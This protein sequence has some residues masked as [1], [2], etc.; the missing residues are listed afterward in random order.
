[1][2]PG[3]PEVLTAFAQRHFSNM[4]PDPKVEPELESLPQRD[5]KMRR[6][7]AK[8]SLHVHSLPHAHTQNAWTDS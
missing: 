7:G 3:E 2:V 4:K 5:N 1:M 8:R 6:G